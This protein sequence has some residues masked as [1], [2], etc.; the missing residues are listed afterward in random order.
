MSPSCLLV[1]FSV[2]VG[3]VLSQIAKESKIGEL[4]LRAGLSLLLRTIPMSYPTLSCSKGAPTRAHGE[5]PI[6]EMLHTGLATS[7][8]DHVL[9]LSHR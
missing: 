1:L 7:R 6:R 2:K 4:T 3:L 8:M 9:L 5:G